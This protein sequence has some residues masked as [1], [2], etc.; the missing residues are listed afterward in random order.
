[1]A[2]R[3]APPK[4]A[5]EV[6]EEEEEIEQDKEQD[7]EQEQDDQDDQEMADETAGENEG[8]L[9]TLQFDQE[10]S[11]RP[12]KPIATSTLL[13]RLEALS[14][15]LADFDQGGVQLDSLKDV[16]ASLAHR[17]LLQ[18]KD[19]GVKAYTACCLVDILRLFVPEAPYSDDQLKVRHV[20]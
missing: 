2:R 14:K 6:E 5:V 1:M 9:P 18:H 20:F 7:Q 8:D 11:W 4:K 3:R 13:K 15:E 10:L 17:N 12:A 19:R 16:A